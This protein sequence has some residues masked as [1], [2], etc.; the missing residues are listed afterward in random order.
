MTVGRQA[1]QK[2]C[3]SILI[4]DIYAKLE[5]KDRGITRCMQPDHSFDHPDF[6]LSSK[7][8]LTAAPCQS[9]L[10]TIQ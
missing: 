7:D 3:F 6:N 4:L 5:A 8:R 1:E 10:A 9:Y 2:F